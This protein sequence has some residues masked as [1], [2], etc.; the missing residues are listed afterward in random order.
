MVKYGQVVQRKEEWQKCERR[1][2]EESERQEHAALEE[3][4]LYLKILEGFIMVISMEGDMIFLSENVSKYMGLT[5]VHKNTFL[6]AEHVSIDNY[7]LY[8]ISDRLS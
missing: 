1:C 8:M 2:D 4:N 6:H 3:T 7:V 5:Q